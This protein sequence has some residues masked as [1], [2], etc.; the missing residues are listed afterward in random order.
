VSDTRVHAGNQASPHPAL[1]VRRASRAFGLR[2][3][4]GRRWVAGVELV[5]VPLA[6]VAVAGRSG[7][8]QV[9]RR[10]EGVVAL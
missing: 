5:Q 3:N 8:S 6:I 9:V 10:S 1:I 7:S 2:L 4:L